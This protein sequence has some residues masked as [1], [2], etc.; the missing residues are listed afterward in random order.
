MTR[1]VLAKR[2]VDVLMT[3]LLVLQMARPVMDIAIHELFGVFVFALFLVHH[4]LNMSWYRTAFSGKWDLARAMRLA[5]DLLLLLA[6]IGVIVS[7]VIVSRGVFA[8][9]HSRG[10]LFARKLH[11]SMTNWCF[12]LASAHLGLHWGMVT[13]AAKHWAINRRARARP[14]VSAARIAAAAVSAY[15]V[16]ACITHDVGAK[17]TMYYGYSY[18]DPNRSKLLI[19]V[20]LLAMMGLYICAA[21]YLLN[22]IRNLGARAG[23]KR[24]V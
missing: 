15:G 21:Y 20:D 14:W 8:F 18:W 11:A 19:F 13:G 9:M 24:S 22:F 5:T 23:A 10:G 17:L 1:K 6:L 7:S 12:L 16:F 4:L 3:A 2:A